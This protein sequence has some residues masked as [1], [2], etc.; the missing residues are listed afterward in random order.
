MASVIHGATESPSTLRLAQARGQLGLPISTPDG[1]I[2]DTKPAIE[3]RWGEP[4]HVATSGE[5]PTWFY[6][7]ERAF[8]GLFL[9]AFIVPVPIV[10]PV[11]H[12]HTVLHFLGDELAYVEREFDAD[13]GCI[14]GLVWGHRWV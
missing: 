5:S 1:A 8:S 13:T 2:R 14:A 12:R 6:L 9:V 4:D 10:V 3:A 7:R 11:G